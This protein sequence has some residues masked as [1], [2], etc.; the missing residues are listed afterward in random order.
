MQFYSC[1]DA[2]DNRLE[3][4]RMKAVLWGSTLIIASLLYVYSNSMAED[5]DKKEQML[6][7]LSVATVAGGCF[8]CVESGF[9]KIPGVKEVISGYSGG[10]LENPE[11][12]QVSAGGTG[13][14]EAV[15]IYYDPKVVSY[16]G[17]LQALW[18]IADPTDAEGQ[19]VD[20]GTQYRP[21]IFYHDAEQKRIAE[22]SRKA[23]DASG[24]YDQPVNIE[25]VPFKKFYRAE[26]Y[27]Q[28]YYKKNPV[29]YKFY[30]F[31]SGRYQFIDQIW[32]EERNVDFTKFG[33]NQMEQEKMKDGDSKYHKPSAAEIKKRLTELQY[34][35]T[36]KD[37]TERPF[38]NAYWDEKREGIYVDIVTGEPLFSS[39]D[40]YKSGTGWPSFTRPIG[41]DVVTEHEDNTLFTSRTEIR[42]RIG[43][44]H[45]GHVFNDGPAPTGKRYCMNSAAMRFIPKEQLAAEGYG[46][47]LRLFPD[48]E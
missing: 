26:E 27:H 35:V 22:A 10:T 32:G 29:R 19:F 20:R 6:D 33:D 34:D 46:D 3:E 36:Q 9:E 39:L 41:S 15:Q 25:I 8:W 5:M 2:G 43:D 14:T 12:K 24:R 38:D 45:L 42:S 23:L 4:K 47:Y 44:S 11:Y 40:K 18:R 37:G 21:A 31:N 7:G 30:T 28:D 13:H 16:A 48:S 17:L 1:T